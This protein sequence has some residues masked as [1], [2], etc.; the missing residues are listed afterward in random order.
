LASRPT[1]I[2]PFSALTTCG[3]LLPPLSALVANAFDSADSAL[4]G[5]TRAL[6]RDGF[7]VELGVVWSSSAIWSETSLR[8]FSVHDTIS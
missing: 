8:A 2:T 4:V 5:E 6:A 1:R 3:S 7:S